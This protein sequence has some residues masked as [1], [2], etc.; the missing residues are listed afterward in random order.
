MPKRGPTAIAKVKF[1]KLESLLQV[2]VE[3]KNGEEKGEK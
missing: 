3:L 1:Q 2:Q